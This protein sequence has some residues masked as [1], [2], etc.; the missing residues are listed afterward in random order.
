MLSAGRETGVDPLR[1]VFD[2]ALGKLDGSPMDSAPEEIAFLLLPDFPLYAVT[3][4]M[5]ALRL[6]NRVAGRPLYIW[7]YFSADGGVVHAGN[8]MA[9]EATRAVSPQELPATVIVCAGNEPTQHLTRSDIR[10]SASSS[11]Q[12]CA[13]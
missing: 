4:A 10:R 11:H 3:P 2:T 5:E 9:V 8:G 6:A 13:F 1:R 7:S 12:N